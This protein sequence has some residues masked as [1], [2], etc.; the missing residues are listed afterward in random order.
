MALDVGAKLYNNTF[1]DAAGQMFDEHFAAAVAESTVAGV[2]NGDF[3]VFMLGSIFGNAALPV[4]TQMLVDNTGK[5]FML[6]PTVAGFEFAMTNCRILVRRNKGP[7]YFI[8]DST[9]RS[10][11]IAGGTNA[12]TYDIPA[13]LEVGAALTGAN[14]GQVVK[15][16]TLAE[17]AAAMGLSGQAAADFVAEVA[18][19]NGFIDAGSDTDFGKTGVALDTAG[20]LVTGPFYAVKLYPYT[21][22]SMGGVVTDATGRV[23]NNSNAPIPHL[24]AVGET[25]NRDFYNQV[26]S[27]GA[28]LALY[29]TVSYLAG[30]DAAS[31]N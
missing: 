11:T 24:Y 1:T 13:S 22:G 2:S 12:G 20:K 29:S 5:R 16:A 9:P 25:S 7:Y 28:S 18:T 31:N 4:N 17:L 15:G 19:Y 14:A 26:Y 6:E 27:G 8:Y 21:W 3:S 30:K 23:L 10:V